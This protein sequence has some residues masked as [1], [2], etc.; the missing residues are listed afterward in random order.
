MSLVELAAEQF[1]AGVLDPDNFPNVEIVSFQPAGGDARAVYA[2]LKFDQQ[3]GEFE[4]V[5]R[6]TERMAVRVGRD[7]SHEKGGIA[8]ATRG[9]I[10][11]RPDD[12]EGAVPFAYT[13]EVR[14]QTSWSWVLVFERPVPTGLGKR[15][16]R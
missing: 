1:Y 13:G 8:T 11:R 14:E 9:D 12:A 2:H 3:Q 6:R 10:L 16:T 4:T 5:S 15:M 7:E